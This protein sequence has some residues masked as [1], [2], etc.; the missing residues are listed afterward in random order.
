MREYDRDFMMLSD[1]KQLTKTHE[2]R[3]A[4]KIKAEEIEKR[5]KNLLKKW[6]I[7]SGI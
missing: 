3:Y 7:Y 4:D 5:F 6:N 2:K 1:N